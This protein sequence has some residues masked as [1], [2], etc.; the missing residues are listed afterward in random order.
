MSRKDMSVT[1][2]NLTD[3]QY[4]WLEKESEEKSLSLSAIVRLWINKKMKEQD[5]PGDG[6]NARQPGKNHQGS[7]G[8]GKKIH[9]GTRKTF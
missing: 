3:N 9:V 5:G 8:Q 1:V 7:R 4:S 2:R 6:R